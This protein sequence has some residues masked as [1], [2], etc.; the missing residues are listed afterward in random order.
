MEFLHHSGQSQIWHVEFI[1]HLWVLPSFPTW[2]RASIALAIQGG[3]TIDQETIH[4][5]M[6]PMLKTRSY[7]SMYA[8]GNHIQVVSAKEHFTTSD[9]GVAT[10]F[11]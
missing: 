11:E 2:P 8:F 4:M 5:S 10:T 1:N 7:Q 9:S 6:S 3:D